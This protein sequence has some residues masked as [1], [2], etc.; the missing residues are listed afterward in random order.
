MIIEQLKRLEDQVNAREESFLK[1]FVTGDTILGLNGIWFGSEN[2]RFYYI[3]WEGMHVV[4]TITWAEFNE[5]LEN[6]N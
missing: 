5:W 1:H 2:I 3:A 6:K 4:D